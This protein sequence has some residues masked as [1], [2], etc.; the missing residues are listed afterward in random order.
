ML[1]DEVKDYL[2]K[3]LTVFQIILCIQNIYYKINYLL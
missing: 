3:L 2:L 1:D